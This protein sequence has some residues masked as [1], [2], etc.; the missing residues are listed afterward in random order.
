MPKIEGRLAESGQAV[1]IQLDGPS[2]DRIQPLDR[3][4]EVWIAPGFLDIQVNG[5]AGHDVNAQG[6]TPEAVIQMVRALWRR[7]VTG[8]CP[9]VITQSESHI[10][11]SLE[12]IT[13]A[14]KA[15]PL[16]AR[17][18]PCVHVEGPHI[19]PEDGPRGAHPLEHIRPP[20]LG[21]YRCWQEAAEGRV[22]IITLSPEHPGTTDYIRAVTSEGVLV[23]IGHTAA[24]GEQIRA[25]VDAGARL[26]TH[27]GNGAHS[28]IRR[29]P[30]YI[31]DQLADDRLSAS[32]IFDGHHLPP[33]VMKVMLRAKTIER[34]ILISDAVAV[35]GMPPGVY[36]T[37]V[38]GKVELLPNGRLNLYGT[39][40]LAGSASS[41]PDGIA[42]ALRYG[43]ITLADAVRL[44]SR[45]PARLLRLDGPRGL[46]SVYPGA[47]ADLTL[48]R[49]DP[50]SGD[51][52]IEQTIVSGT[53]VYRREN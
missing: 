20:R 9:T 46:G 36:E 17:S 4:P 29:H 40:Y 13:A 31:W 51:F 8:V 26:S 41:L 25:A 2:I 39:S 10:C 12:V 3:Q 32:L 1:E 53:T 37:P 14:C 43:G 47:T 24:D 52:L 34:A 15:D 23:A 6:A 45:N 19:S 22:G 21:E 49:I 33:P 30:N 27:L 48:F 44:V 7:G 11:H 16:I 28:Q 18:I 35:S 42:N 5:Y 50:V 38:G